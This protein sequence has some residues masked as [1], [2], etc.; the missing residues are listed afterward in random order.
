M[1]T[2]GSKFRPVPQTS[3]PTNPRADLSQ[4]LTPFAKVIYERVGDYFKATKPNIASP[5][6]SNGPTGTKPK[7]TDKKKQPTS[8]PSASTV[9]V[10]NNAQAHKSNSIKVEVALPTNKTIEA[11]PIADPATLPLPEPATNGTVVAPALPRIPANTP[12]PLPVQK[13]LDEVLITDAK[14]GF[15]IELASSNIN[16]DEYIEVAETLE[17]PQNVSRPKQ[18]QQ[19]ENSQGVIGES[20]DQ[21]QRGQSALGELQRRSEAIYRAIQ[22]MFNGESGYEH[23][24][25][26]T[27]DQEPAITGDEQRKMHT[28]IQKVISLGCF[29]QV[30]VEALIQVLKLSEA[31]LKEA[32]ATDV[33]V[34]K[35]W[36]DSSVSSWVQQL[37]TLETALKAGRT[38]MRVLSGGR[39]DRQLYSESVIENTVKVFQ[40]VADDVIIPLVEFRNSGPS[41]SVFKLLSKHK[42]DISPIFVTCQKLLSLLS[43]LVAKVQLSELALNTLEFVASNLIFVDNAYYEKDSLVGV[44]KFDGIRSA[45]MDALCQIFLVKPGQRQGIL[46]EILTSLSKLPGNK[47]S[48]K[49]Y[50]LSDGGSIQPVSALIMRLVQASSARPEDTQQHH[51]GALQNG[52]NSDDEDQDADELQAKS[53]RGAAISSINDESQGAEQPDVAIHELGTLI[54]PPIDDAQRNAVIVINF[55]VQRAV[56]SSRS[57]ETPFRNILDHCVDDFTVCLESIDWPSAELLL[58]C[59]MTQMVHLFEGDRTPAPTKN[60]ALEILGNMSAAISRLCSQ[61]KK[62]ANSSEGSHTDELS[63]FLSDLANQ[64]LD[65]DVQPLQVVAWTGPYRVALEYLESRATNDSQIASASAYLMNVWASRVRHYFESLPESNHDHD[66]ELGRL[67][68]RLRMMVEDRTWLSSQFEFSSVS[69]T[70]AKL[71]YSIVL[72]GSPLCESFERIFS[73]LLS[74]MSS[75]Q[76]TVRSKSL[77]SVNTVLETDPSILD[78]NPMIIDRI[79]ECSRDLSSLVREATLGLMGNCIQ[80]R[81]KLEAS[82]IPHIMERVSDSGVSVRR[83]AMRLARDIYLRNKDRN[84][85]S[86]I[87]SGLLRRV[88]S[89]LDEGVKETARQM[90]EEIW[91]VPFYQME[92]TAVFQ[93]SLVE[94]TALIIRTVKAGGVSEMLDKVLQSLLKS[95]K[96][97]AHGPFDVCAKLVFNLFGYINNPE[98]DDA[99]IPSGRDALH[100]LTIFAKAEP[101]LFTFE[102]MRLLKPH[103]SSDNAEEMPT[104]RAVVVILTSVLPQLST[105]HNEFITELKNTL[106]PKMGKIDQRPVLQDL[107]AC[108]RVVLDLLETLAPIVSLTKS[109]LIGVHKLQPPHRMQ[110]VEVRKLRLFAWLLGVIAQHFNLDSEIGVFKATFK[111]YK[112]DTVA[113]LMVDKLT[114]FTSATQDPETRRTAVEGIAAVCQAWPRNYTLPKVW[115][116]FQQAFYDRD[117]RLENLILQSIKEFLLT[118]EKRSEASSKGDGAE[119]KSLTVMGGTTYDDV[120][121][122]TTQR[123]LGEITRISLASQDG[124]ALLALEVLASI[125]RQGLTH[126]KE[127]GVT[128]IT[129]ETS[130]NPKISELA[131]QE[132]RALHEKHESTIEREYTK[133]VQSA[134]EYQRDVVGDTRGATI[135]PP[136]AKLHNMMAVLKISKLKNRQRFFEKLVGLLE[137]D[138]STLSVEADPPPHLDFSRFVVENIALFEYQS[139]GELQ[140]VV[141]K[142]EQLVTG[143]G[144]SLAQAMEMEI[145]NVMTD[146]NTD[147]QIQQ[148]IQQQLNG[149]ESHEQASVVSTS[150]DSSRLRQ[151]ATSAIILLLVWESR[152][153]LRRLYGMGAHRHDSKAK[154]LAKDLNR[155]PTKT[156][157]IHWDK[158]WEEISA[159]PNGLQSQAL[160]MQK[161]KALVELMN[162]DKEVRVAD[163][164]DDLDAEGPST[165]SENDEDGQA[166]RGRKRKNAGTPSGRKK[167]Q[168]SSSQPRK[169]G[170]PRK[171]ALSEEQSMDLDSDGDFI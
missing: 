86:H 129:L 92:D 153:H 35:E 159:I 57:G 112:D 8:K 130:V 117:Q 70:Q 78:R 157:G 13:Q 14:P 136:Q 52:E 82:F 158:F 154:A 51:N 9:Q 100:V 46:N 34:D 38:S 55:L 79:L 120:A 26:W 72:L 168:R 49:Q 50:K 108:I 63:Q 123:F 80:M 134:Y 105:V 30:P 162:I 102:Q 127:T 116:V 71:S 167:R 16:R 94:H 3:L 40:K 93:T 61:A 101:K 84:L 67:A 143:I 21:R 150:V 20:L 75:D 124:H 27:P 113:R 135:D 104:F 77:K 65:R 12:V 164:D 88:I 99:T 128:M 133:A 155:T 62:A 90:V 111:D 85:R 32:L 47:Q 23:L 56:G 118:E 69:L 41:A 53:H 109:V 83:R 148:Q 33:Q 5:S 137:F 138:T 4:D 37:P 122:A 17:A 96:K 169:R 107:G 141:H 28:S 95:E 66:D 132:H 68:Y 24:V 170:R 91:F 36:D 73:M 7:P 144:T 106:L 31:S 140:T 15:R 110:G 165:P 29:D 18:R 163:G 22:A 48:S 151:L 60:M 25:V 145:F 58:R 142:M 152:T 146:V 114:P 81:P 6:M 97:G 59:L 54:Q 160:M 119:K 103:L 156:Q 45:A 19:L 126:P 39:E 64:A 11:L 10:T 115:T 125:N 43:E 131:F 1:L 171:N 42:K 139:V 44:Q 147:D 166:E 98:S 161:C 87:A 2:C 121:S 74:S 76:A 89:D 149:D